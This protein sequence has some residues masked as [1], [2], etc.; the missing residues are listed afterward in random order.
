MFSTHVDQP[1]PV[2]HQSELTL[3]DQNKLLEVELHLLVTEAV[4]RR[5]ENKETVL[6]CTVDT[7]SYP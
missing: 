3:S 1:L 6:Y 4:C 5:Y 2:T 7:A